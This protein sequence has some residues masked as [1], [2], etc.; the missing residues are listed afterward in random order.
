MY[1]KSNKVLLIDED[2]EGFENQSQPS[3]V[4]NIQNIKLST[5]S[6]ELE[7]THTI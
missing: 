2:F 3:Y 6:K 5:K 1:K 7:T 4:H